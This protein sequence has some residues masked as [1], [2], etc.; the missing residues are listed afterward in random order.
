MASVAIPGSVISIG[1]DAFASCYS[2]TNATIGNGVTRIGAGAFSGTALTSVTI[3]GSVTIIGAAAFSSTALT[4]VTVP[5]S[6][7]NIGFDALHTA[8]V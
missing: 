3:P 5:G 7:T 8:P 2:L 1:A 6:V 4:S